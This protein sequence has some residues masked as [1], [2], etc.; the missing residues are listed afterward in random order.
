MSQNSPFLKPVCVLMF[1]EIL[2]PCRRICRC[3]ALLNPDSL[4]TICTLFLINFLFLR[5]RVRWCTVFSFL[6][7]DLILIFYNFIHEQCVYITLSLLSLSHSSLD[8]PP[9]SMTYSLI[10]IYIYII[11]ICT[12]INIKH[13]HIDIYVCIYKL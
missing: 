12:C 11:C 8:S 13:I 7:L 2:H 6:N 4:S 10:Y 9:K 1:S 5:V 3:T